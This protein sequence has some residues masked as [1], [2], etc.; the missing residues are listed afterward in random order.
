MSKLLGIPMNDPAFAVKSAFFRGA[1]YAIFD[2]A[3]KK[4]LIIQD[5][6]EV[7]DDG[8]KE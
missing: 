2:L 4:D 6:P 3:N 7:A 8:K 1:I 5:K